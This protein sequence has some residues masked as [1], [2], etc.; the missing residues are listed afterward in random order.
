MGKQR[1][2]ALGTWRL[3]G[4]PTDMNK[5]RRRHKKGGGHGAHNRVA[6]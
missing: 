3:E 6:V 4:A 5:V 1:R 2:G